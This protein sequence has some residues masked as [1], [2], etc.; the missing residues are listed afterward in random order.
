MECWRVGSFAVC[1]LALGRSS[2]QASFAIERHESGLFKEE[3]GGLSRNRSSTFASASSKIFGKGRLRAYCLKMCRRTA[4]N[5]KSQHYVCHAPRF[6]AYLR[7]SGYHR[8]V[9]PT[10]RSGAFNPSYWEYWGSIGIILGRIQGL[11][12]RLFFG[13]C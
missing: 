8:A 5:C 1:L 12:W 7:A 4:R 2:D 3:G 6:W 11:Y 13:S 9:R 10:W